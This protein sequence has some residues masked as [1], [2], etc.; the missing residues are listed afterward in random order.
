MRQLPQEGSNSRYSGRYPTIRKSLS[1]SNVES[2][3]A[4]GTEVTLIVGA[5]LKLCVLVGLAS[6]IE[7]VEGGVTADMST[8]TA[9]G[10]EPQ[11]ARSH[12]NAAKIP[13]IVKIL[14]S[15]PAR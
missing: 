7:V 15:I 11:A 9:V 13:G 10:D 8:G 12:D 2:H 3:Q 5:G 14:I 6:G 4:E 1:I